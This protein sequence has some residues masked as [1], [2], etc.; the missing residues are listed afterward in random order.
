MSA[1]P[2]GLHWDTWARLAAASWAVLFITAWIAVLASWHGHGDTANIL[3]AGAFCNVILAHALPGLAA[4]A[5]P[6]ERRALRREPGAAALSSMSLAAAA[7]IGAF[8]AGTIG[9]DQ[10]PM[11]MVAVLSVGVLAFAYTFGIAFAL[12]IPLGS[13]LWIWWIVRRRGEIGRTAWWMLTLAAAL[14]WLVVG[15]MGAAFSAA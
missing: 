2:L 6:R 3:T 9:P 10:H 15:V 5:W 14:G 12:A 1:R 4:L 11:A 7:G 8:L 13:G